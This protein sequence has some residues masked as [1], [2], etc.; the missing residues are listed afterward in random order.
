M[1]QDV[2]LLDFKFICWHGINDKLLL[3]S[4]FKIEQTRIN[5]QPTLYT[6]T[7][8]TFSSSYLAHSVELSKVWVLVLMGDSTPEIEHRELN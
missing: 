8:F 1:L 3:D 4:R 2:F 6:Q 5:S 7:V